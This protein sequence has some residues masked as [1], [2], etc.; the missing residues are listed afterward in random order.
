MIL[1]DDEIRK[2]K[3]AFI[4]LLRSTH[5]E[6]IENL[7]SWLESTDF[8]MAPCSTVYHLNCV[9]GLCQHSLNVFSVLKDKCFYYS[10]RTRRAFLC[11]SIIISALL[12]DLCKINT[13][14]WSSSQ[15]RWTYSQTIDQG[16]GEKS[17]NYV[18]KFITLS[19]EERLAIRWHMNVFTDRGDKNLDLALKAS[20]L[21]LLIFTSDYESSQL[22]ED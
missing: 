14:V 10:S 11:D 1:S 19:E 12:H 7:I 15:N 8:F 20:P 16:H 2:N 4:N 6:N 22:L 21:V 18:S 9:G 13:Y 5:R 3:E 17:V